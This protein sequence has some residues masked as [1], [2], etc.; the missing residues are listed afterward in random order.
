MTAQSDSTVTIDLS[1]QQL[2][3]R[4]RCQFQVALDSI[5]WVQR[6]GANKTLRPLITRDGFCF[7]LVPDDQ[8]LPEAFYSEYICATAAKH[9]LDITEQFLI[10]VW[11]SA[12]LAHAYKTILLASS[13]AALA[14][15]APICL[16]ISSTKSISNHPE[17]LTS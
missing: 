12:F 17:I 16:F 2:I 15:W 11:R 8:V 14:A 6:L 10:H 1:F 3:D 13:R 7:Q 5:A 9:L 4:L